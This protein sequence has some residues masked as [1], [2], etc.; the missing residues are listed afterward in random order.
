MSDRDKAILQKI[1]G[2]VCEALSY[3]RGM[4]FLNF[5][6]DRKT[7]SATAFVLGQIGELTNR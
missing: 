1:V 2:Y 3:T 6:Q 5:T 7:I 4:N